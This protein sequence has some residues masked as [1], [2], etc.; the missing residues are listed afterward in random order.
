MN[1]LSLFDGMSCGQLALNRAQVKYDRYYASEI[2]SYAKKICYKNHPKTIQLGSVLYIKPEHVTNVGLLIGGSPCQSLSSAGDGTGLDGKSKL[3]FEFIRL[4]NELNP[5]WFLLENVIPKKKIWQD[6]MSELMGCD[7][8]MINSSLV[9][10]QNRKRL[11]WTNIPVIQP[12]DRHIYLRDILEDNVSDIYN[13]SETALKRIILKTYSLPK[14][15]PEKTGTINT[16]NNYGQL[17]ANSG[18]TLVLSDR[19]KS[20]E[21]LIQNSDKSPV[22]TSRNGC[23]H[24]IKVFKINVEGKLK[25]YQDKASCL[26]AG[27]H[28]GGNHSDMDLILQVNSNNQPNM[29]QPS[30]QNRFY[31]SSGKSAA[32]TTFCNRLNVL[33]KQGNIR[34]L[35]EIECERLQTLPDGYTAGVSSTQRYKM[36]GNGWNVDTIAHILKGINL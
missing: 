20:G 27:A 10:A 8:I 13:I 33:L 30:M 11:Y 17:S 15:E 2:D 26:T 16:K 24:D 31:D 34:R 36:I 23:S 1:V 18:T 6:K 28:S 3:F 7:P 22:L 25:K 9:S 21:T 4:K 5:K 29:S 14:L 32:L 12:D 19:G 35:T